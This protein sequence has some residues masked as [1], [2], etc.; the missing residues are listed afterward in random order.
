[1]MSLARM[2]LDEGER[3]TVEQDAR[4]QVQPFR[5]R[6]PEAAYARAITSAIDHLVRERFKLP[7]LTL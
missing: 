7:T 4:E 6:M 2:T 3:A 1:M 5:E